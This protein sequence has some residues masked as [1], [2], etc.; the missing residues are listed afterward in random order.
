MA[1][2]TPSR[3][4]EQLDTVRGMAILGIFLMNIFGFALPLAAYLNPYYTASTPP[5][6]A[7]VWVI[8]NLLFQGKVLAIFSL[9]FGATLA[10]L[11]WRSLQWNHRRL[12]ILALFGVIHGIGLWDGDILLAYALTGLIATYL[13]N[14][15]DDGALLKIAISLYIIGLVILLVLGWGVNPQG[16]WQASD[17]QIF[18]EY[19]TKITG[20]VEGV[21]YRMQEI[22]TMLE[23]LF[24]QYGWQLIALMIIGALLIRNGW[25]RGQFSPAHY[26]RVAVIFIVP[27]L[28]VQVIALYIQSLFGWSYFSTSIIGYI[29]NELVI[30]F[31]SLGYIALVY[32]FWERLRN[33]VVI[34]WLQNIGKMALSNYILQTLICTT[35]FYQFGYFAQF[36]RVELLAFIPPVWLAN[37]LFSYY[38]LRFFNQG[39]LEWAWR[40]LTEKLNHT[41][42]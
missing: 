14:Q 23:M 19:S 1:T 11:Q 2:T 38:W 15:Y 30:P 36:T 24:V 22:Q 18:F 33:V 34:S 40:R 27:S 17:E 29:I 21:V 16:F 8:F 13:L 35:I 9:L 39:P 12:F 37:M 41:N 20:G 6:D 3:R 10:L 32:G 31:Q 25:L 7:F 42:E 28:I 5:S 4:I 26:R